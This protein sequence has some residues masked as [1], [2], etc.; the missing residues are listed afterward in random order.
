MENPEDKALVRFGP[1]P[2]QG[3]TIDHHVSRVNVA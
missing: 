1:E 3:R 2:A